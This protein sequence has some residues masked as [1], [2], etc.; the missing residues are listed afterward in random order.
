MARTNLG[1]VDIEGPFS[2]QPF[3]WLRYVCFHPGFWDCSLVDLLMRSYR[4][5]GLSLGIDYGILLVLARGDF[6]WHRS[7]HSKRYELLISVY[8]WALSFSFRS[9]STCVQIT[10]LIWNIMKDGITY[11]LPQLIITQLATNQLSSARCF[12]LASEKDIYWV[13]SRSSFQNPDSLV[14]QTLPS[15]LVKF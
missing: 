11:V 10:Y 15:I 1:L 9:F 5:V 3:H 6:L 7:V 13:F 2:N 14:S 8:C 4:D 12:S